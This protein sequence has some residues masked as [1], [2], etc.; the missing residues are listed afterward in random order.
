MDK[1]VNT[2][3]VVVATTRPATWPTTVAG[4]EREGWSLGVSAVR[5]ERGLASR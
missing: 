3:M 5:R 2:A 4:A 1:H